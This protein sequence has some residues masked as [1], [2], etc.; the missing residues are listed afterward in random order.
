MKQL[1]YSRLLDMI[2]IASEECGA[3]LA[4]NWLPSY[5]T[6]TRGII[7]KYLTRLKNIRQL[8]QRLFLR[9]LSFVPS[10]WLLFIFTSWY[11]HHTMRYSDGWMS[12]HSRKQ[13]IYALNPH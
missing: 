5:S 13:L 6:R 11:V 4:T 7:I 10:L 12:L 2:I 1:F 9:F 3:E 8:V